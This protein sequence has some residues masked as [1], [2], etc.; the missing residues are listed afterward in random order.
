MIFERLEHLD[1]ENL[2]DL[3]PGVR[4]L[5]VGLAEL[6]HGRC[7]ELDDANLV[8]VLERGGSALAR[9]IDRCTDPGLAPTTTD[10]AARL[11]LGLAE[12]AA[13]RRYSG[14]GRLPR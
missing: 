10:L 8:R 2:V 3:A 9:V 5:E 13:H 4:L 6:K 1:C 7:W 14:L 11:S 12:L